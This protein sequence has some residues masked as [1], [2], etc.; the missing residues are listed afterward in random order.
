MAGIQQGVANSNAGST[1]DVNI[2]Q[3]GGNPVTTTVPVSV[4]GNVTVVQPTGSNLHTVIDSG[5]VTVSNFPA[6][7]PVS[8]TVTANQGTSPWVVSGS[9]TT[10]GLTQAQL[11]TELD[12]KFGDLGQKTMAGSAPVVL[13]SDQTGINTFLD[14]NAVG[15]ISAINTGVTISTNGCSTVYANI[16]GTWVGTLFF[17]GQDG[18]GNWNTAIAISEGNGLYNFTTSNAPFIIAVAGFTQFRVFA[19][20]WTSG[21]ANITLNAGAGTKVIHAISPVASQF[22]TQSTIRQ[23]SL[24]AQVMARTDGI[25]AL[26]VAD[27]MTSAETFRQTLSAS[28]DTTITFSQ[29]IRLVRVKNES[30]TATVF[31]RDGA[32]SSDTPT[33]AEMVGVAPVANLPTGEYYPFLTTTIHLRSAGTPTCSITGFY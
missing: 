13:A 33:N 27:D 20:A 26:E 21:T 29:P 22:L 23:N 14:K 11:E 25:N 6:T 5:T 12:E 1:Q 28:T 10:T 2:T 3:V 17:Q 18:D 19:T 15:T 32:I 16:T 9:V 30:L 7:Q 31:V 4:S 24:D 8:G